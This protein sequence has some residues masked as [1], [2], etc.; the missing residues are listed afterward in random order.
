MLEIRRHD[1]SKK[2][3]YYNAQ[4][5]V[6]LLVMRRTTRCDTPAC[7]L[8]HALKPMGDC[9]T[10]ANVVVT[11]AMGAVRSPTREKIP[12]DLFASLFHSSL[13]SQ[14]ER[15]TAP[16]ISVNNLR[17]LRRSLHQHHNSQS[18]AWVLTPHPLQSL[19]PHRS[20]DAPCGHAAPLLAAEHFVRPGGR[21][22]SQQRRL[23]C[24]SRQRPRFDM[25]SS[26]R[27]SALGFWCGRSHCTLDKRWSRQRVT[28][29]GTHCTLR[30]CSTLLQRSSSLQLCYPV[31]TRRSALISPTE[32][33][34][35]CPSLRQPKREL[36]GREVAHS[37]V[38]PR[39]STQ[40]VSLPALSRWLPA[41]NGQRGH[42]GCWSRQ[43]NASHVP[44]PT[45]HQ[46]ANTRWYLQCS[47]DLKVAQS[48]L[49]SSQNAECQLSCAM[50]GCTQMHADDDDDP[51]IR[52]NS[53]VPFYMTA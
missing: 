28:C 32:P 40:R 43:D 5:F 51:T 14:S 46:D 23:F 22:G 48:V 39:F 42:Q 34:V 11:N 6:L 47:T 18:T 19:A 7:R 50:R 36:P 41:L 44:Q 35:P 33:T 8:H 30:S 10:G 25:P 16:C 27:G 52:R 3:R 37:R 38:L 17:K 49:V 53:S 20:S 13:R 12:I 26:A 9:T 21:R 45:S 2:S 24:T 29:C 15:Q 4:I 31:P 1:H